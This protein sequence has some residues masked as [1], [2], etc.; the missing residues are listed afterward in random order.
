M[1][2]NKETVSSV[3]GQAR[4]PLTMAMLFY[5]VT[6]GGIVSASMRTLPGNAA[7]TE[8][9]IAWLCG[10]GAVVGFI[11]GSVLGFVIFRKSSTLMA[12]AA[13]GVVVGAMAGGLALVETKNFLEISLLAFGGCW[14]LVVVM[15][16]STR[17]NTGSTLAR[18]Q[19]ESKATESPLK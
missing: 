10:G 6:I 2:Q 19:S 3:T 13:I 8:E 7:T 4:N 1:E 17:A 15:L 9:S 5:I 18:I 11:L 12:G 14:L 16:L